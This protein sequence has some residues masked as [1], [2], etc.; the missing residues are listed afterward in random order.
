M[1][2]YAELG[3]CKPEYWVR[4]TVHHT[5]LQGFGCRRVAWQNPEH[6]PVVRIVSEPEETLNRFPPL[7][8]F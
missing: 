4:T 6:V 2:R 8:V 5:E 7:E 3:R 1:S